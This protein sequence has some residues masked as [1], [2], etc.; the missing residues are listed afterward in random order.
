MEITRIPL[1]LSSAY[2]LRGR[3]AVLV[4]TGCPGEEDRL[5]WAV[6]RAGVDP[7]R[8]SLVLCTHGHG[9]HAGGA[10]GVAR[11]TGAP[12]AVHAADAAMLRRGRNDP[13]VPRGVEA[14]L[15]KL[16]AD[17]D[18]R[19]HEPEIIVSGVLD[20]GP[21]GIDALAEPVPGHTPG[22][23]VVRTSGGDVIAGDLLRGGVLGGAVAARRPLPH[24]FSDRPA[25]VGP[26]LARLATAGART[27]HLGHGGPVAVR[28]AVERFPVGSR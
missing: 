13:L 8:L 10:A 3:G 1:R 4:D 15:V 2:L 23:L 27:L 28:R 16:F 5:L 26:A 14:R 12:V 24:Y 22:S 21:F 25:A 9:D 6:A 18:P 19:A 20:L 11:R 7:A 17:V